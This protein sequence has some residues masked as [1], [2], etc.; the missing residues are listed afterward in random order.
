MKYFH[1]EVMKNQVAFYLVI[2]PRYLLER[3]TI[4]WVKN[5]NSLNQIAVSTNGLVWRFN[6]MRASVRK[7]KN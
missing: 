4:I 3:I 7:K 5:K 2:A 6:E 1:S